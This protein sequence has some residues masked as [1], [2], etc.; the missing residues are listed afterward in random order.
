MALLL[1][2]ASFLFQEPFCL[3]VVALLQVVPT[4]PLV[5]L[6]LYFRKLCIWDG[7]RCVLALRHGYHVTDPPPWY[8]G[9]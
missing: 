8:C 5:A 9:G 6:S 2:A 4:M 7:G 3:C 1:L